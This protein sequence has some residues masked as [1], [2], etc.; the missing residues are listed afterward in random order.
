MQ[1]K[2][3]L[4][5]YNKLYYKKKKE[6]RK[7][8]IIKRQREI[9]SYFRNL[10]KETGC[11]VCGYNKSGSALHYHHTSKNKEHDIGRMMAQ[12]RA[13]FSI[14]EEIKKCIL[15]CANCHAELHEKNTSQ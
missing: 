14:L 7:A 9:R 15:V 5:E 4:K 2:R 13:I 8:E 6:T 12:G 1:Q 10:K 11:S 3:D